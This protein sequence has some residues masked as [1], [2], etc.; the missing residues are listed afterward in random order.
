MATLQAA[1]ASSPKKVAEA[2]P[3]T[4]LCAC[5]SGDAWLLMRA[6]ADALHCP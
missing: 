4:R 6:L 1:H 2:G 5:E 3:V